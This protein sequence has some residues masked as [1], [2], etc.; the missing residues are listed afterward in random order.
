MDDMR[1][2]TVAIVVVIV[3][4]SAFLAGL[5]SSTL[6]SKSG[7]T[8]IGTTTVG[9]TTTV[10]TIIGTTSAPTILTICT[11]PADGE[12]VMRVLNSTS[13][14]PIVSAPV[15]AQFS[16]PGCTSGSHT[17]VTLNTPSTNSTGYVEFGGE[18]GEYFLS[19]DNYVYSVVVSTLPGRITC[20]TLGIPSGE[21]HVT[22]SGFL[23][24]SCRFG[25]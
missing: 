7:V 21:T 25:F 2:Q 14:E 4:V 24:S 20:V 6:L 17:T 18:V 15:Q 12:L 16:T 8:T 23:E 22:Y 13:G 1:N 5:G 9:T 10:T 3:M 19:V 11:I